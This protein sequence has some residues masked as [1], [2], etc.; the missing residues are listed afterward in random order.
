[1]GVMSGYSSLLL[2]NPSAGSPGPARNSSFF[3]GFVHTM[4]GKT[5]F[6]KRSKI[7]IE[8]ST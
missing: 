1:M 7:I 2:Y 4:K 5:N 3:S 8:H 6:K